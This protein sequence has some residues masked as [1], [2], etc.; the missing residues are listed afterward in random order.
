MLNG[1]GAGG[2]SGGGIWP[3]WP[4]LVPTIANPRV[5]LERAPDGERQPTA[6]SHD[7]SHLRERSQRSALFILLAIAIYGVLP[8][9]GPITAARAN[10]G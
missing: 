2:G 6:R 7:S 9:R 3:R 4:R 8:G 5:A 1:P 10:G